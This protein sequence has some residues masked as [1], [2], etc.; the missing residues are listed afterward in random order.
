M[1]LLTI[2]SDGENITGLWMNGQ[3]HYSLPDGCVYRTD[4]AVIENTK[5][6][7]DAYFAGKKPPMHQIPLLPSGTAFQQQIWKILLDIPYGKTMTYGQVAAA[8][9]KERMSAQAVGNAVGKNPISILIPCHRVV[10]ARG[11]TGYAGGIQRKEYLLQL[12]KII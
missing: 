2:A 6:W 4:I 12:E 3:K 5:Q 11:L 10:G 8:L 7:L 9:G 1:G